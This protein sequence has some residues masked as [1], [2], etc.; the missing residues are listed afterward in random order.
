MLQISMFGLEKF[1]FSLRNS[2]RECFFGKIFSLTVAPSSIREV[3]N[4]FSPAEKDE[5]T[6]FF[7]TGRMQGVPTHKSKICSLSPT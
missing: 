1:W 3:Q 4:D 6:R 5:V 7:P 2:Q